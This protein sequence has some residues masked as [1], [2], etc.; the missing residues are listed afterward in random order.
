M[1]NQPKT[2]VAAR[3]ALSAVAVVHSSHGS[4]S[5]V[6]AVF[7]QDP[8]GRICHRG[9]IG[10]G[11]VVGLDRQ[12]SR[13][14]FAVICWNNNVNADIEIRLYYTSTSGKI[15]EFSSAVI[16]SLVVESGTMAFSP[17]NLRLLNTPTS[18][19]IT[20]IVQRTR[21]YYQNPVTDEICHLL[22]HNPD[23][24]GFNQ[25]SRMEAGIKGTVIATD[26]AGS[27]EIF[28]QLPN[29]TFTQKNGSPGTPSFPTEFVYEAGAAI[30]WAG[31]TSS[32]PGGRVFTVSKAN[33]VVMTVFD[34]TD[35]FKVRWLPGVE[36]LDVL[37]RAP[38]S[39]SNHIVPTASNERPHGTTVFTQFKEHEIARVG[40]TDENNWEIV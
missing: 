15:F 21:V 1:S 18:P 38:L 35:E 9:A 20:R 40:F 32:S 33:K 17:A 29:K 31:A 39:V 26:A 11:V 19:Q 8:E 24:D 12:P 13:N 4:T 6:F 2:T 16:P 5:V 34:R 14:S 36:V 25:L 30:A 3:S 22:R 28:Y 27:T 10:D 23:D 37:P 7:Y